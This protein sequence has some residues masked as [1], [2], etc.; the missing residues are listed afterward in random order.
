MP[1][2]TQVH[3]DAARNNRIL[4]LSLGFVSLALYAAMT[5]RWTLGF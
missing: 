4:A 1:S 2:R 5:W 3:P